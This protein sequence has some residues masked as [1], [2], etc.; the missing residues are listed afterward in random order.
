MCR[1]SLPQVCHQAGL[2]KKLTS[3]L[4]HIGDVAALANR[5][6]AVGWNVFMATTL[7]LGRKRAERLR[8][9]LEASGYSLPSLPWDKG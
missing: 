9:A 1:G 4:G 5:I 7:S 2:P 6:G 8:E 3:F